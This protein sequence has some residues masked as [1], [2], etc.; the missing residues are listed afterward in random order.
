MKHDRIVGAPDSISS[1]F[2]RSLLVCMVAGASFWSGLLY[3]AA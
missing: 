3:L 1:G 2:A